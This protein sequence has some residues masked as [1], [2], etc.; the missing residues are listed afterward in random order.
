QP[1]I[2]LR[3]AVFDGIAEGRRCLQRRAIDNRRRLVP[4][5]CVIARRT[6]RLILVV[7]T[8]WHALGTHLKPF[9]SH[10]RHPTFPRTP[11][12]HPF[13]SSPFHLVTLSSPHH[14]TPC[15]RLAARHGRRAG[16]GA[17]LRQ[18]DPVAAPAEIRC[19]AAATGG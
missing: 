14:T 11:S 19:G 12:P 16:Q 2:S 18:R 13:I 17:R 3:L 4:R 5:R 15:P 10:D 7:A 9:P 1:A 8:R 6:I